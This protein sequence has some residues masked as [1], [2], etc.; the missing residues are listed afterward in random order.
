MPQV[1][2]ENP[3]LNSPYEDP[4]RHFRFSDEGVTDEI[5]ER[6]RSNSCFVPIAQPHKKNPKQLVFDTE[7]T[8]R[9]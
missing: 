5:V 9:G 6:Q 8:K 3:R 4:R 2:I 7:W 1:I